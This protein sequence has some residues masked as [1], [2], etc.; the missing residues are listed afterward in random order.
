MTSTRWLAA[1]LVVAMA[2][3]IAGAQGSGAQDAT[4]QVD[5]GSIPSSSKR[6]V[7]TLDGK[8]NVP[9]GFRVQLFADSVRG[10]RFMALGPD[11]A[12]YVSLPRGGA[13]GGRGAG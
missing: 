11:G 7:P 9:E 1:A 8:L 2:A 5:R 3:Q 13:T 10:A 6:M 12:V 4:A